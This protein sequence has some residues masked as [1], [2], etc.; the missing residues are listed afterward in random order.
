MCTAILGFYLAFSFQGR[1]SDTDL[2]GKVIQMMNENNDRVLFSDL[3]NSSE[4]AEREL[5]AR[6]YEVLFSLP[7]YLLDEFQ[8]T[9]GIPSNEEIAKRFKVNKQDIDLV[10]KVMIRD[11]RLPLMLKLDASEGEIKEVHWEEVR[12]FVNVSRGPV[13][14]VGWHGKP[15]PDFT[16]RTL[17]GQ[18]ITDS[19]LRGKPSLLVFYLTTCPDCRRTLPTIVELNRIL[20]DSLQIL[21][22][23]LDTANGLDVTDRQRIEY[24]EKMGMQF[25]TVQFSNAQWREFGNISVFPMLIFVQSNGDIYSIVLN[26]QEIESLLSAA[27]GIGASPENCR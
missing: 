19:D 6:L 21:G 10:L 26:Y 9:G 27:R 24:I 4:G 8:S 20:G 18:T 23:N 1:P 3:F 12:R 7:D 13:R 22:I 2:T 25:P 15:L 14:L 17:G 11:P 16:A 5:I